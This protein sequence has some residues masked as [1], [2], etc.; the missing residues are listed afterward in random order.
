MTATIDF[1]T[2]Q[3]TIQ[4]GTP[5]QARGHADPDSAVYFTVTF[6]KNTI[7]TH[8]LKADAKG[9]WAVATNGMMPGRY[10]AHATQLP[11]SKNPIKPDA[12]PPGASVD[13]G[14]SPV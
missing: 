3:T 11:N 1:P 8:N 2:P 14:V 12:L 10:V 5:M 7:E 13:F 9:L 6:L 4:Q